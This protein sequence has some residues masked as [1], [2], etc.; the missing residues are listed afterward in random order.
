MSR[1]C[2]KVS[3]AFG[4]RHLHT[5]T[6]YIDSSH[7]FLRF[8]FF[9]FLPFLCFFFQKIGLTDNEHFSVEAWPE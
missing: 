5:N 9:F 3:L 7:L 6:D 1:V 4:R 2:V 8:F